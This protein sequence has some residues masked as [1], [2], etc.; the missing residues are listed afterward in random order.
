M[1]DGLSNTGLTADDF[2]ARHRT[3]GSPVPTFAIRVGEADAAELARAATATSG[4]V[5]D[6][7]ADTLPAAFKDIRGC[8]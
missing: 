1:T 5:V 2:L 6:A 3:R 7:G 4:H 8:R